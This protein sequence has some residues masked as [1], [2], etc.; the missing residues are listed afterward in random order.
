M[1][2]YLR[3]MPG[4]KI[5]LGRRGRVRVGL[6]PRWLRRWGGAGGSGWSTEAGSLSYYRPDRRRKL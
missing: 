3:L 1:S 5:R 2:L 6:R 4:V